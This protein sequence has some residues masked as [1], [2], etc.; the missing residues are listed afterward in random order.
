LA[1]PL[2][3]DLTGQ[4]PIRVHVGDDEGLLDDSRRYVERAVAAGIDA[5]LDI[6]MRMPHGFVTNVGRFSTA[7]IALKASGDFLAERLGIM[8]K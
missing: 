5:K 4:P 2:Y 6:W 1:S 3:A 8:A 7:T